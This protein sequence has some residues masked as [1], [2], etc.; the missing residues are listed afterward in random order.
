M[1]L[2]VAGF[3][4][5]EAVVVSVLHQADVVLALAQAAVSGATA[6]GLLLFALHAD[7][8]VGH[9]GRLYR[10]DRQLAIGGSPLR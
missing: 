10:E 1:R 7:V 9:A 6:V 5:I 2:E 3:A 4:A 8:F